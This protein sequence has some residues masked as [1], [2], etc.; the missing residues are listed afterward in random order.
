VTD[1]LLVSQASV[2]VEHYARDAEH[3][4]HYEA[5]GPG[6]TIRLS[7]GATVAVDAVYEGSFEVAGDAG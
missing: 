6:D 4:W 2:R 1:Y 7:N 3:G 5:Y